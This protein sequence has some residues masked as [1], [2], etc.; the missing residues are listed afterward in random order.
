MNIDKSLDKVR[1][2]Y[3][4]DLWFFV[5]DKQLE[6]IFN[7]VSKMNPHNKKLY[8]INPRYLTIERI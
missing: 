8:Y 3:H 5:P 2:V 4:D 7:W 1:Y 6:I